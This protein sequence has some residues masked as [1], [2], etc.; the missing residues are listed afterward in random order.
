MNA[1]R[2][3]EIRD[4]HDDELRTHAWADRVIDELLADAERTQSVQETARLA[5]RHL[6]T[7]AYRLRNNGDPEGDEMLAT[8]DA[9]A[10][11]L[12]GGAL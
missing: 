4:Q 6:R 7:A 11:D 5:V 9:L 2:I 3:A 12:S 1:D 10:D 8:A